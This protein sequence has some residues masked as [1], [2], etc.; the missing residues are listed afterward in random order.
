MAEQTSPNPEQGIELVEENAGRRRRLLGMLKAAAVVLAIVVAECL[1]A[2]LYI[3]SPS[4]SVVMA[5]AVLASQQTEAVEAEEV[6]L[7]SS[8]YREIPLGE[9]SVSAY[10]P[11]S[12]TTL[13]ID[14]QLYGA[15]KVKDQAELM[16]RLSENEHRFREQ[17]IVIVRSA[18][19]TD[20]TDAGLGLIKRKILEKSNRTLGKP[21][22]QAVIFSQFSFL[23]Q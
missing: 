21:L 13:R 19:L 17:V 5:E 16:R 2:Y 6:D 10:Q 23:E 11:I 4:E 8:D 7:A 9:F 12:N 20:L 15:V 22:L 14:F 18:E 3:P 1:M